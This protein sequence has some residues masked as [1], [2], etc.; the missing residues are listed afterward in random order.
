[1]RRS[2]KTGKSL[3]IPKITVLVSNKTIRNNTNLRILKTKEVPIT[4]VK[5][6]LIKRGLIRVGTITPNDVLRKMY[7][8]VELLCG[9]VQNYNKDNI[10]YNF[11]NDK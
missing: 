10:L 2:Y 4:K 1:M 5:R 7:E 9:D 11:I 3:K 6:E 8:T